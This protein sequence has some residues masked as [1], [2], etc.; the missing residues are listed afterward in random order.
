MSI[1]KI[2]PGKWRV[3][4]RGPIDPKT[5]KHKHYSR[6]VTG[7]KTAAKMVEA[8]L[9][10]LEQEDL[11][12][13]VFSDAA[14]EWLESKDIAD[15]TLSY[16]ERGLSDLEPISD[17]FVDAIDYLDCEAV[18]KSVRAGYNRR[19]ARKA[20][21]AV[22]NFCIIKGYIK[23]NPMK[24]CQVKDE[25]PKPK[26]DRYTPEEI[27]RILEIFKDDPIE[28]CVLVAI[29][30]GLRREEVA[31]LRYEDIDLQNGTMTIDKARV[32]VDGEVIDKDTKNVMSVR[33]VPIRGYALERLREIGGTGALCKMKPNSMSQ[34][35]ERVCLRNGLRKVRFG[36]LR[37][38]YATA[39]AL[40]GA[41]LASIQ[42]LLG[43]S[44][45]TTTANYIVSLN[46]DADDTAQ[47]VADVFSPKR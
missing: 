5:G 8:E 39:C 43:H 47:A 17:H 7:S 13:I 36:N 2:C 41:D 44:K 46:I 11:V 20:L 31:A 15:N 34:R 29:F 32:S 42:K 40:S 26:R 9:R 37:H 18:L 38:S 35:F 21:N 10:Q 6:I 4:A 16:Y 23:D 27:V 24:R 25:V 1:E 45:I 14:Q 19:R 3:R 12:R 30:A 28:A 33:Q 22:L